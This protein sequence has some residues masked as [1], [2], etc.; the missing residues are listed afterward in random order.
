VK[1]ENNLEKMLREAKQKFGFVYYKKIPTTCGEM[2][3][4]KLSQYTF[5]LLDTYYKDLNKILGD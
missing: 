5:I 1:I 3:A 2:G 4:G